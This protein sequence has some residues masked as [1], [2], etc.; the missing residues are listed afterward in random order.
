MLRHISAQG[1][2]DF[3]QPEGSLPCYLYTAKGKR[4]R[5][6]LMSIPLGAG[7]CHYWWV[8]QKQIAAWVNRSPVLRL[9]SWPPFYL[10]AY[11]CAQG[12][13]HWQTGAR[14]RLK[15]QGWHWL[16]LTHIALGCSCTGHSL[17][18][19]SVHQLSCAHDYLL[20]GWRASPMGNPGG[21]GWYP[22]CLLVVLQSCDTALLMS[23]WSSKGIKHMP[24]YHILWL[25]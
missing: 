9:A 15:C 13:F 22:F 18:S 19:L 16:L 6:W 23:K 24:P 17:P 8:L 10:A 20:S 11:P 1:R 7:L 2:G 5:A 25:K 12:S 4:T 21:L 3:I 14:R